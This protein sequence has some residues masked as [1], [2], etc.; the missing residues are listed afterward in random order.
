MSLSYS[1]RILGL[2]ALLSLLMA[3]DNKVPPEPVPVIPHI[4]GAEMVLSSAGVGPINAQTAFNIHQITLAFE[5]H[6]YN[7]EQIQT[8]TEGNS[9]LVI[10]VSKNAEPLLLITPNETQRRIFSV[11]IKDN[12]VGNVLGH[13]LGMEYGAIYSYGKT[14]QCSLGQDPL[15]E[16]VLCYAPNSGNIIYLFKDDQPQNV[17]YQT[18]PPV[19]ALDSW[20]LESIIW[21][22]KK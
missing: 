10:R 17:A 12:R 20:K 13:T 1:L 11:Q 9:H 21:K 6:R 5:E 2:V 15:Q 4:E 7:V 22:P 18:L 3:C 8:Y 14:E 19:D 16:R